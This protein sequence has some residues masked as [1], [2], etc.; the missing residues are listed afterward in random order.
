MS[1]LNRKVRERKALRASATVLE[2]LANRQANLTI[3][4]G[5]SGAMNAAFQQAQSASYAYM[6]EHQPAVRAVVDYIATNASELGLH[7]YKRISTDEREPADEHP[8]AETMRHPNG[9]T[10]ARQ[11]IADAFTSYL[12]FENTYL[13]K[14]KGPGALRTLIKVPSQN[15]TVLGTSFY[16]VDTYRVFRTDGSWIDVPP[17]DMIHWRG[18]TASDPRVGVSRLETLRE[19]LVEEAVTQSANVELARSG[20]KQPG[21]IERPLEAPDW[22]SNNGYERFIEKWRAALKEQST[23]SP[24]LEEGMKF[25]PLGINPKDAQMLESRRFTREEVARCFGMEHCPPE[26]EEERRQFYADVLPPLCNGLCDWLRLQLL[27]D[28][29]LIDD[30]YFEF[31]FDEKRMSDDRLKALTSAAGGPVLTRNEAR[32]LI[33]Q[34]KMPE[35]DELITP[36][37]VTVGGK[38]SPQVMPIQNPLKP[39]QDGSFRK[40]AISNGHRKQIEAPRLLLPRR[41]EKADRRDAYQSELEKVIVAWVD[42]YEKS[43]KSARF[44]VKARRDERWAMELADDL[45]AEAKRIVAREGSIESARLGSDF[46]PA[47][48][49]NYLTEWTGRK[50]TEVQK[51]LVDNLRAAERDPDLDAEHVFDTARSADSPRAAM[52]LATGFSAW[53]TE[54]AG[55]QAPDAPRRLKMW[56]VTCGNSDH[57]EYDGMTAPLGQTFDNGYEG[58]PADHPGCQCA[59]EIL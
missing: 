6:Y 40:E 22:D 34:P 57:P 42:R 26:D 3:P 46:D 48:I 21:Y 27:L 55:R 20:L 56:I 19:V 47:M 33:N 53:A 50:A 59:L 9:Q 35:G 17:E 29:Y 13:V 38:P 39:E 15:V 14:L 52:G 18:Q 36:L 25:V 2:S 28:E 37:N 30:H 10:S 23:R 49:V 11:F 45:L 16:A 8:A 41:V 4:L 5:V 24:V 12:V 43:V 31:S 51:A 1:I 32:A 58:P 44:S 7:L 54:E